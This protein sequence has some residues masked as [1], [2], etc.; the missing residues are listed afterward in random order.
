MV[1]IFEALTPLPTVGLPLTRSGGQKVA[2]AP[3]HLLLFR[4]SFLN[5]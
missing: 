4:E 2:H 5:R 1:L 3:A